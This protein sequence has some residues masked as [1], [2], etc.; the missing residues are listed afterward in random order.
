METGSAIN[1]KLIKEI[2]KKLYK[3]RNSGKLIVLNTIFYNSK[4]KIELYSHQEIKSTLSLLKKEDLLYYPNSKVITFLGGST[5]QDGEMN[6][7]NTSIEAKI[8][9]KGREYY[10]EEFRDEIWTHLGLK[11]GGISV[12]VGLAITIGTLIFSDLLSCNKKIPEEKELK[13]SIIHLKK[14]CNDS[15]SS[16]IKDKDTIKMQ[17]D[18]IKSKKTS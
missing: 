9:N 2:L 12:I 18:T 15:L 7:F 13:I 5:A 10:R 16:K 3:D 6:M 8:T 11:F 1:E 17:M 14:C 4:T